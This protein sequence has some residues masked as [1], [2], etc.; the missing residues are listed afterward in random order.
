MYA[1]GKSNKRGLQH[2]IAIWIDNRWW[3]KGIKRRVFPLKFISSFYLIILKF[4]FLC[5]FYSV[6]VLIKLYMHINYE[7]INK[8][9]YFEGY[10][11]CSFFFFPDVGMTTKKFD[12]SDLED[13]FS[14]LVVWHNQ[15]LPS[16]LLTIPYELCF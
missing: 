16:Y 15:S 2:W 11:V 12:D 10:S 13:Q 6:Y 3:V 9:T 4:L 14:L 5:A 7:W 8:Y 1:T